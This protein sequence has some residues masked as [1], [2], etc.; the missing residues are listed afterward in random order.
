MEWSVEART[1]TSQAEACWVAIQKDHPYE[2]PLVEML[3][4]SR[5]NGAY[6]RWA[7]DEY[8]FTQ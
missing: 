8:G 3:A 2:V 6:A 4:E 5:V 7:Q 1:P